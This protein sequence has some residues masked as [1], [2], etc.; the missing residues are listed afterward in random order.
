MTSP[1]FLGID[2]GTSGIKTIL[3]AV[4]GDVVSASVVPLQLSTPQPG[5]AEQNPDD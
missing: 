4:S 1:L 5:W 2:I 3:V